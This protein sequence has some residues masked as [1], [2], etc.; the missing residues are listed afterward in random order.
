IGT[1][2]I[3]TGMF[4]VSRRKN[5]VGNTQYLNPAW[6]VALALIAFCVLGVAQTMTSA[7]GRLGYNDQFGLRPVFYTIGCFVVIWFGKAVKKEFKMSLNKE[8]LIIATLM[9]LNTLLSLYLQ[10]KGID[11][12]SEAQ[13]GGLFFPIALGCCIGG[14]ALYSRIFLRERLHWVNTIGLIVILCGVGC[15]SFA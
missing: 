5:E 3:V 4:A 8:M 6:G 11:A 9:S 10:F 7:C 13:Q 2:L 12:L 15:Y 14:F 1:I